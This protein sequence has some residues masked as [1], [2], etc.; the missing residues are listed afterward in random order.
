M[1]LIGDDYS[2]KGIAEYVEFSTRAAERGRVVGICADGQL[3]GVVIFE[4]A[5]PVMA[6]VHVLF[7]PRFRGAKRK[8]DAF[9]TACERHFETSGT[10]KLM[11]L[12][13]AENRPAVAGAKRAGFQVEGVLRS[14]SVCDGKPFDVI[15]V[16]LTRDDYAAIE[17]SG[18]D[19]RVGRR[20]LGVDDGNKHGL[21]GGHEDADVHG[22]SVGIAG[23]AEQSVLQLPAGDGGRRNLAE[24]A[25]HGDGG[26]RSD[27]QELVD[28]GRPDESVSGAKRLRKKRVDGKSSAV[29]GTG[30]GKRV[31]S[32][33]KRRGGATA[34]AK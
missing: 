22:R 8:S 31:G 9:R 15:A 7:S 2:P 4:Q 14:Y 27:Q 30:K 34:P 23:V 11:G 24:R 3:C 1:H 13:H 5:T 17:R 29:N 21:D 26:E 19:Q 28:H 18:G 25:G 6:Q 32:Q 33:R 12:I 20:D 10:L 16:G